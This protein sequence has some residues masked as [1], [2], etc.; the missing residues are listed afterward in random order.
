MTWKR[1]ITIFGFFAIGVG[2][3]GFLVSGN[4]V[5]GQIA[6]EPIQLAEL[7]VYDKECVDVME[8]AETN[9][10]TN[11]QVLKWQRCHNKYFGL[12]ATPILVK[13][14]SSDT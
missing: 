12:D 13:D 5:S 1:Y 8:L 10:L 3:I 9:S 2:L 4:R 14:Y 7:P 11:E 6:P